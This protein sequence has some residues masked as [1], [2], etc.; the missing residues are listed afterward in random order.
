MPAAA[1]SDVLIISGAHRKGGNTDILTEHIAAALA[2]HSLSHTDIILREKDIRPCTACL[3]CER[4]NNCVITDDMQALYPLLESSRVVVLVPPLYFFSMS[5]LMKIF[6]DRCQMLYARRFIHKAGS[7]T[8]GRTGII[9]SLGATRK[10]KRFI[11]VTLTADFFFRTIGI[12]KMRTL[13]FT[14]VEKRGDIDTVKDID[15][16]IERVIDGIK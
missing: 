2:R 4:D 15:K 3:S 6:I 9:V 12:R 7:D 10:K 13:Y 1:S 16:R 8:R 5:S 11:G 14:K